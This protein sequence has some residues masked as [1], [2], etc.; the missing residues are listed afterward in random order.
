MLIYDWIRLT[1]WII[2]L[3]KGNQMKYILIIQLNSVCKP[4]MPI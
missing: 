3:I 1:G 4:G 2:D